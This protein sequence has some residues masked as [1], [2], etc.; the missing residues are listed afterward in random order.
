MSDLDMSVDSIQG[1]ISEHSV[2]QNT[3]IEM[4]G[5][6]TDPPSSLF[7]DCEDSIQETPRPN[8]VYDILETP[9]ASAIKDPFVDDQD[10]RPK[11]FVIKSPFAKFPTLL[12]EKGAPRETVSSE[13]GSN[14]SRDNSFMNE[15]N[16][17]SQM[18]ESGIEE[19][20]ESKIKIFSEIDDPM[21]SGSNIN[22][23]LS[24]SDLDKS[25]DQSDDFHKLKEEMDKV[26][27]IDEEFQPA[28]SL[29]ND[30]DKDSVFGDAIDIKEFTPQNVRTLSSIVTDVSPGSFFASRSGSLGQIGGAPSAESRPTWYTPKHDRNGKLIDPIGETPHERSEKLG[31][32]PAGKRVVRKPLYESTPQNERSKPPLNP[33]PKDILQDNFGQ[34]FE[35]TEIV[36]GI[37]KGESPAELQELLETPN[38]HGKAATQN[39]LSNSISVSHLV[40]S[41]QEKD[42]FES[43]FINDRLSNMHLGSTSELILTNDII[44]DEKAEILSKSDA[45]EGRTETEDID[46]FDWQQA[47]EVTQESTNECISDHKSLNSEASFSSKFEGQALS[48]KSNSDCTEVDDG[49]SITK[50]IDWR[51]SKIGQTHWIEDEKVHLIEKSIF[52]CEPDNGVIL[53]FDSQE[54]VINFHP[55]TNG[56][57]QTLYQI[58]TCNADINIQIKGYTKK[59]I[60]QSDIEKS[61]GEFPGT[62]IDSLS[63]TPNHTSNQTMSTGDTTVKNNKTKLFSPANFGRDHGTLHNTPTK[64]MRLQTDPLPKLKDETIHTMEVAKSIK[65]SNGKDNLTLDSKVQLKKSVSSV[66]DTDRPVNYDLKTPSKAQSESGGNLHDRFKGIKTP[67]HTVEHSRPPNFSKDFMTP[68]RSKTQT[69]YL[70]SIVGMTPNINILK[71]PN[72]N[73]AIP[74]PTS[75]AKTSR[76]PNLTRNILDFGDVKI[77]QSKTLSLKISNPDNH[78]AHVKFIVTGVFAIPIREMIL[79]ARSFI[80]LPVMFT[81]STFGVSEE[82][83]IVR[84]NESVVRIE[85]IG[86]AI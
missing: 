51:L 21:I 3:A 47:L 50:S 46:P 72:R 7:D 57:Y 19:L 9:K 4:N 85:L 20:D 48:P 35:S 15:Q 5:S 27:Q 55:E 53:A 30:L 64:D 70:E 71:T 14:R 74:L 18:S 59:N 26:I 76:T 1:R 84:K 86:Y 40:V 29:L 28:N 38:E 49:D 33:G 8:K 42:S 63:K 34:T 41:Q 24:L 17:P 10:S 78:N 31:A 44:S 37:P 68:A 45:S 66:P 67:M 16:I 56:I 80:I 11:E 25:I 13:N 61:F 43:R 77:G 83:L 73:M 60:D 22:P 62:T 6:P 65:H 52:K 32:T 79:T 54:I 69:K 36:Q 2:E 39:N 82:R 23:E 58:K 12:L 75:I 81:P